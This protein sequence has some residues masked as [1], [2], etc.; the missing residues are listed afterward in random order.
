MFDPLE[1]TCFIYG[2]KPLT[3]SLYPFIIDNTILDRDVLKADYENCHGLG[4]GEEIDTEEIRRLHLD[5][6]H[7]LI[8]DIEITRNYLLERDLLRPD[9][10]DINVA[11]TQD[12]LEKMNMDMAQSFY[13][14]SGGTSPPMKRIIEPLV[15]ANLMPNHPKLKLWNNQFE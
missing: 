11:L 9:N 10:R 7:A 14:R 13:S 12:E 8:K 6:T 2:V 3:C 1:Y 4:N 5:Y 15:E